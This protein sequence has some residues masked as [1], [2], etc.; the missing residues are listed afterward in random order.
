MPQLSILKVNIKNLIGCSN[1]NF[2]KIWFN[3]GSNKIILVNDI[4]LIK[5]DKLLKIIL[6]AV[7]ELMFKHNT[8]KK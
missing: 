7:I 5:T 8:P 4:N 3:W 2:R 1:W 6:F